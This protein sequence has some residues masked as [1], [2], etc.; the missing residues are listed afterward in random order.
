MPWKESTAMEE[1]TV[2]I[3]AHM[4]GL[5]SMSELCTRFGISRQTG[6]K[7]VR[8][9]RQRGLEGLEDLSR[10]PH[11]C[12]HRL[13]PAVEDLLVRARVKHPS[14]GPRKLLAWLCK[15]H[16]SRVDEFPAASTYGDLLRR[17][18]HVSPRRRRRKPENPV[19]N[20]LHTEA[21]ND[22]W[23]A[24]FKGEFRM[25]NGQY[26]Y[27][28]TLCDAH[29]RYLLACSAEPSTALI[30]AQN[31]MRLAFRENGL[32]RAIRTDNGTPFVG[33]GLSGLSILNVWW[34]KL[35]IV[36]QRIAKGRP[37]QN[38]SHER[39]HRTMKAD[40]TRPPEESL[41]PQQLRFDGFRIEFNHVRP[42]E[43]LGQ[44]TPASKYQPSVR[45]Y[46][47]TSPAPEY[48]GHFELRR[49]DRSGHRGPRPGWPS[50]RRPARRRR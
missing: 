36:H 15:H 3:Q 24:D 23:T 49:V 46:P 20:P 37:D 10:A 18:G 35:G 41:E 32:P 31:A 16:P 34:I 12:P 48:P 28:F 5:Y 14:W 45:P 25:G 4:S 7:F 13:S 42:H 39:M 11:H 19:A 2:F 6:H 43:A 33:H 47:E 29:T 50:R 44:E 27:P 30:G 26:C 21:A 22:V 40:T 17:T 8:R 1:R 38:G 9:Y